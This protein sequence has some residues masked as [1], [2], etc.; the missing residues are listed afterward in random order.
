MKVDKKVWW[1]PA[2]LVNSVGDQ[3]ELTCFEPDSKTEANSCSITWENQLFIF[4]GFFE[5]RQISRLT[6]HKLERVGNLT[7]DHYCGACSV[8]ADQYIFLCFGHDFEQCMRSTGP[9][10]QFSE[11]AL[12]IYQHKMIQ[13]SCSDSKLR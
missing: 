11:V 7:F 2:M 1:T 13:T 5:K 12:S 8:M 3:E 4:G 10:K 6:G 9:L